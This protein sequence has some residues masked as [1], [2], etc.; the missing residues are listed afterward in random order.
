MTFA[1]EVVRGMKWSAIARYGEQGAVFIITA[2]L[3]R[4][5]A[6]AAFGVFGMAILVVGIGTLV[7]DL[8]TVTALIQQ[9]QLAPGLATSLFWLNLALGVLL[10]AALYAC[11]PLGAAFF[12]EPTLVPVLRV[13]G[14]G[15]VIAS[16]GAVPR[17][18]LTRD[19][20][21]HR[22]AK[23]Q[24]AAVT[25]GGVGGILLAWNG[26]GVWSLVAQHLLRV[27]VETAGLFA[28]SRFRPRW[29]VHARDLSAV[30]RFSINLSGFNVLGYVI[31][32]VDNLVIGRFLGASALGLYD[33]AWRLI[34]YPVL[35]VSDVVSRT[36]L[37]A[38]SRMQEDDARL[39]RAYIR[40]GAAI[41]VITLPVFAGMFVLA[42]PFI[43]AALGP[44]WESAAVLLAILAPVGLAQSLGSTTGNLY[45][46][47][48]RTDLLLWWGVFAG[49][50]TTGGMFVG[51]LGGLVGVAVARLVLNTLLSPLNFWIALRVVGVR[52]REL[53][54]ALA[55]L[56][57]SAL[58]MALAVAAVRWGLAAAGVVAPAPVLL[59][60]V[61]LGALLYG[62]AL[63]RMRPR[64]VREL[65]TVLADGDVRWARSLL[66]WRAPAAVRN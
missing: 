66:A 18:L 2:I 41:A 56:A 4:L 60:C 10:A 22:M 62:A 55:P 26:F 1:G 33:I 9:K 24:L 39:G 15:F 37:P 16:L 59:V 50:V 53:G 5:L 32:N 20:A 35:T 23:P 31:Q 52:L 25:A 64:V 61:P 48:G 34:Q 58:L 21:F 44:K 8:G 43:L 28:A 63:L 30:A 13:M 3:A 42:R 40:A 54:R 38:L 36:M 7:A 6:P 12:D 51:L 14:A 47:K 11:A 27:S 65:L 19:L 29:R 57:L 46:A 17:G 45:V 49:V